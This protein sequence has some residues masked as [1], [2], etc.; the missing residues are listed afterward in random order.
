VTGG[1]GVIGRHAVRILRE[2]NYEVVTTSRHGKNNLCYQMDV[3]DR[4]S[5]ERA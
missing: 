4:I 1:A 3:L 5:V 2:K